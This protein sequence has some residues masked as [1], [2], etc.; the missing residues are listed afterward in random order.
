[1]EA[2][3]KKYSTV[4]DYFSGSQKYKIQILLFFLLIYPFIKIFSSLHYVLPVPTAMIW[5]MFNFLA[6][7]GF[8]IAF[9]QHDKYFSW[10]GL[11]TLSVIVLM[12][13][14]NFMLAEMASLK[15][16]INWLGFLFV[17]IMVMQLIKSLS[18]AEMYIFQV[19]AINIMK[20]IIPV[21]TMLILFALLV[22]PWY[23]DPVLLYRNIIENQNQIHGLHRTWTGINKQQIGIFYLVL[24]A[25]SVTH[26]HLVSVKF[27]MLIIFF[28]FI[29]LPGM[30]GVRTLIL[31]L[32]VGGALFY[33]LKNGVRKAFAAL[34]S[35]FIV[36]IL[37]QFRSDVI[38]IVAELFDRLPSLLFAWSAMTE[39][40]F[41]IGNGAYHLY[42]Q[43]H[44]DMLVSQFGS[45]RMEEKGLFWLA[46]ESDLV[47][48]IASW[49]VLSIVFYSLFIY[50]IIKCIN[51]YHHSEDSLPIEKMFY[52]IV[53]V[54]LAMG[55]SQD[56]AGG[57]TWWLFMAT[58]VGFILRRGQI[59]IQEDNTNQ[60]AEENLDS[61]DNAR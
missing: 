24:I 4:Y 50:M 54:F 3:Y 11:I 1:M 27:R 2:S 26:W 23:L 20:V 61:S 12:L 36:M 7:T 10:K 13:I 46:P 41:G 5:T 19:K 28:F 35:I 34:L 52:I 6:I 15:W 44:N 39:N 9:L 51:Y 53:V 8:A 29:N 33:F 21:L 43:E 17:S 60:I 38:L 42:V 18:N 37:Y 32:L 49:G 56:N 40:L 58:G 57:L 25:F 22:E 16:L 55:I 31:G 47:Y 45:D 59:A 30:V 14:I 48:F